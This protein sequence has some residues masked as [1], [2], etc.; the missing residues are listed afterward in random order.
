MGENATLGA[1]RALRD[2]GDLARV[3]LLY[4]GTHAASDPVRIRLSALA[5]RDGDLTLQELLSWRLSARLVCLSACDSAF[6]VSWGGEERVGIETALLAAGA[7]NILS[8]RWPVE[9]A[10]TTRIMGV[11][12]R[13][14]AGHGD[15]GL[16]LFETRQA[17]AGTVAASDLAAWRVMGEG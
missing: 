2:S 9:D 1:V 14:Y 16:A 4:L 15:A 7:R 3:D 10:A 6:A 17:L 5:L 8:A 12:L 11:F 13:R